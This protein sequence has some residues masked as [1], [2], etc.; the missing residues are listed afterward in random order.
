M[1]ATSKSLYDLFDFALG[2]M[3]WQ[4]FIDQYNQK[5]DEV[6]VDGFEQLPT[7]INYT[8]AQLIAEAGATTLPAYVSPDSPGYEKSL[9]DLS[10]RTGNIPTQKAFY[11]LRRSTMQEKLQLIQKFGNMALTPEMQNVFLG[12]LDESSEGLITGYFN[13]LTNQRMQIVSTGQFTIDSVNNPR[14]VQGVTIKYGIDDSHF[15]TLT[16]TSRWWTN[17]THITSN[18][19]SAADPILYIKNKVKD[20][21]RIYHYMGA[22]NLEMAKDLLDDLLTHSAVLKKIGYALYPLSAS[23]AV[24]VANAQ[25]LDDDV[26]IAKLNKL[27][28]VTI[29][30]RDSLA[31]VDK[32]GRNAN[33]ELDLIP[34]S[35][36]NFKKENI[37]FVPAGRIGSIQGVEPL[38]FGYSD[39][40][41]ASFDGGR[42]KLTQRVNPETHSLFIESEAAQL[43]VLEVPQYMAIS[44]VTV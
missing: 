1:D 44:T 37:S 35:I 26:L 14:G 27:C 2:D 20:I 32:P 41:V 18:E 11:R 39:N 3:G 34:T 15:D 19:G 42:L 13:A 30:P 6:Q 29:V 7:S 4:G 8:F 16:T 24:A 10:G 28:G 12:L 38:T 17:A 23:D 36:E 43:C 21:R 9:R 22:I 5:Y 31:W 40:N 33:G 25:N